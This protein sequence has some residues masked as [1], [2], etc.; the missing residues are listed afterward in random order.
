[1]TDLQKATRA[2]EELESL[3]FDSPQ[4]AKLVEALE[5]AE[6]VRRR[7]TQDPCPYGPNTQVKVRGVLERLEN[8]GKGHKEKYI[9]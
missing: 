9:I 7:L 8:W 3:G 2:I 4:F 6:N 5:Y 1:M